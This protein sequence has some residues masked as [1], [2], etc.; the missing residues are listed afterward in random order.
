MSSDSSA[1]IETVLQEERVFNPSDET[2]N[3]AS[4]KGFAQYQKMVNS[5]KSDPQKFWGEAALEGL[6]WF[7]PF[8]TVLDWTD[9]PFARWFDG[10]KT[11]VSYNCLD[12]HV[13]Q[14]KGE[15]IAIIWE[16][17]PGEV[18]KITYK[19]L[20]EQV[21]RTANALKE[22]GIKKG[23][24]VALYMPMVPEAAVAMLACARIGAPHSVVF[25]GFSSEALRDRINDG[26]AKAIITADGGFRKDKIISLKN[27]V[28]SAL[29]GNSCPSVESVL[30]VKRTSESISFSPGRD[31]WWHELVPAQSI[32]CPAEE[33]D[34]E[35][36]LFVL[37]TSGS[38]GKPKGVVHTTA[39]Y[40]L[41]AHM[42]FQWIFDVR[43]EEIYW[44]TAD[45]GWIT[46]HSYIVYGPLSNGSTTVMYEGV[47][48]PSNP[49][50]FWDLI[51]RHKINIFY[52]APTAIRAFMKSGRDIPDKYNLKSLRLLGTVG[53]PINPEAWIWYRDVIGG[54]S[55]PIVDTW[56]QTETG[57]VMISPLPGA[58]PT[59][60]GSATLPLP[61][62]EAEIV[63][64]EGKS[65][66]VNQGGYLV[67]KHPWPG[68]MRTVHGNP[69]RFRESYWE[70]L[71][72]INGSL[73]YFA[74]DGARRDKDGY[75]WIMGRVDDVINVSGH[76]LGTMEIE[77]ALVSHNSVAEAA[78]VG[79]PDDIKGEAIVAFVTLESGANH[80]EKL[81]TDL[82]VHVSTEIGAIARPDEI[83]FT[84]SLPKTRSG[85]IMRRL[86][87][88]LAA[89]EEVKG[90][91]STLE[92]RNVLDELRK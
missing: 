10:G 86:L 2:I 74:G 27:A 21:C 39:G 71:P 75:F 8:N 50:A 40:N 68:M 37:Y 61:G 66:D 43:E 5:A 46:G 65:V 35:D 31:Y 92:D 41:W 26:Q 91:T 73:V 72:P 52:T 28:D 23:D 83:R 33:M 62:I 14:G 12:R 80:N 17:E 84:N 57:G 47:P 48:R 55:C 7:K 22:I 67:I 25:G 82:K 15:K 79:K 76:R 85:K 60:P 29:S 49:G 51:E 56:W 16:G 88:A 30:V 54:N 13:K 45:V 36:R 59:K 38:T 34:S 18:R 3:R 44:C 58:I 53:E 20:L 90:D 89:G 77:S 78:V 9:P 70:Y 64:A 69:Q 6:H 1:K 4:I 11:N 81:L 19:Q 87:R 63:N 24:L 32:D 42:T